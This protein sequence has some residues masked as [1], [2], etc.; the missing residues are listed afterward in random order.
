MR[1]KDSTRDYQKS[2][3]Y[4]WENLI[5]SPKDHNIIPY[6]QLQNIVDYIWNQESLRYP[7]RVIPLPKQ[8]TSKW[9]CANRLKI[10]APEKGLPSWV[11]IHE[12]C[13][14]LTITFENDHP[15]GGAHGPIFV[16]IYMKLIEKYVKIPLSLLM[17]TAKENDVDFDI[18]AIPLL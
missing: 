14:C 4:A 6:D 2:K 17:Y 10:E 11:L 18:S 12:L 5:I 13:H 3:L 1:N 8:A 16:G 9:A 15:N 7:P